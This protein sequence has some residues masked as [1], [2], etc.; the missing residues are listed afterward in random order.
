MSH[1]TDFSSEWSVPKVGEEPKVALMRAGHARMLSHLNC[2]RQ[3][4]S[5][6]NDIGAATVG[7]HIQYDRRKKR[8]QKKLEDIKNTIHKYITKEEADDR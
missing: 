1:E 2:L 7:T 8:I 3:E 5:H 6:M 4:H